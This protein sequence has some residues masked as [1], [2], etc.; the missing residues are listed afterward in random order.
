MIYSLDG[1]S[2]YQLRTYLPAAWSNRV[3]PVF[4]GDDDKELRSE[5]ARLANLL[6]HTPAWIIVARQLLPLYLSASFGSK[7][8][9]RLTMRQVA[10]FAKPGSR[11]QL[12]IYEARQ[13]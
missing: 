9:D 10:E 1:H 13:R 4:Y 2:A 6:S 12:A 11:A 7:A 3:Q 8:V 5:E